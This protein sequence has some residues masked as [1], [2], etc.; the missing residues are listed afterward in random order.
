GRPGHDLTEVA[1]RG[2]CCR[3]ATHLGSPNRD[4]LTARLRLPRLLNNLGSRR[5]R[6]T[7]LRSSTTDLHRV[8]TRPAAARSKNRPCRGPPRA[9][10]GRRPPPRPARRPPPPPARP[11]RRTGRRAPSSR[12]PSRR[13]T[14]PAAS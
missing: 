13:P 7:L 2:G 4:G 8:Q 9:A 11:D 12:P 1:R 14:R 10:G 5:T 3:R 6:L